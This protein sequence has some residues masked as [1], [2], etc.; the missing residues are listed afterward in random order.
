MPEDYLDFGK[1]EAKHI[2]RYL[3][4][5]G[6]ALSAIASLL[7]GKYLYMTNT[8]DRETSFMQNGETWHSFE[9]VNHL[10][11][12]IG[13]AIASFVISIV[14][15][16]VVCEVLYLIISCMKVYLEKNRENAN[17]GGN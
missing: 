4:W 17:Q 9:P 2:V 10:P 14:I 1:L 8:Y 16:N 5:A 12:G 6:T 13:G 3:F 7:F 11:L 15:L